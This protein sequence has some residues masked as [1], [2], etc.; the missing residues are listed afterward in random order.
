MSMMSGKRANDSEGRRVDWEMKVYREEK[1]LI[2]R[3]IFLS[4]SRSKEKHYFTSKLKEI[5]GLL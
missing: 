1:I 2:K 5:L 4:E 3:V